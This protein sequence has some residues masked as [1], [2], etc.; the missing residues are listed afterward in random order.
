M[1]RCGLVHH[2]A[3][4]PGL[5]HLEATVIQVILAGKTVIIIA[6]Y[7]SPSRPLMGADLTA[8]SGGDCRSWWPAT[9][10]ANA[11]IGTRGLA[12][13]GGNSYVIMPTRTPV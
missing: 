11:W 6:A 10:M 4:V 8:C 3:P 9:S 7:F 1:V 2:S 13:D 5:T 12:R